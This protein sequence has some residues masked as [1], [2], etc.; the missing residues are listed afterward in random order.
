MTVEETCNMILDNKCKWLQVTDWN[1][2]KLFKVDAASPDKACTLLKDRLGNLSGY[3][4]INVL[5]KGSK[6]DNSKTGY[7]YSVELSSSDKKNEKSVSSPSGSIGA[8]EH[9]TAIIGMMEKN[10]ELL[11][12]NMALQFAANQNDPAKWIPVMKEVM[13]FLRPTGGA[14]GIAG[15][16][17]QKKKLV[18]DTEKIDDKEAI[19]LIGEEFHKLTEKISP[20]EYLQMLK[21][22]NGIDNIQEQ[23]KKVNFLLDKIAQK[24]QLLDSAVSFLG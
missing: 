16:E 15:K 1:D 2:N 24:P 20:K 10:N 13:G 4:R 3:K 17:D 19:K 23:M 21:S 5:A 12:K 11:Q 8:T 9:V 18:S 22:L 14:S 7:V 6:D